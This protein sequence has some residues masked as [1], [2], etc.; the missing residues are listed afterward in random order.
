AAVVAGVAQ[1]GHRAVL[2]G[3]FVGL[4]AGDRAGARA[5][6]VALLL[7]REHGS[8]VRRGFDRSRREAGRTQTRGSTGRLARAAVRAEIARAR[9]Q[10]GERRS[11]GDRLLVEEPAL[12]QRIL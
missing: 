6:G 9:I 8:L 4:S 1:D 2:R 5:A 7:G 3:Q 10:A 11:P 12:D